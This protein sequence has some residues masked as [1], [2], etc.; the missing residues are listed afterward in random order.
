MWGM[1]SASAADVHLQI[2]GLVSF[3]VSPNGSLP[4]SNG[5]AAEAQQEESLPGMP[6]TMD[7]LTYTVRKNGKDAKILTDVSGFFLPG[8]LVSSSF[9]PEP[10]LFGNRAAG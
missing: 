4:I 8:R 9:F 6:I 10:F 1:A 7:K 2:D 5:H 3:P